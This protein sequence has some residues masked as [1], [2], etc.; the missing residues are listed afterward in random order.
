MG[1][2]QIGPLTLRLE[3]NRTSIP[4]G[5]IAMEDGFWDPHSLVTDGGIDPVLRGLA[6]T[7]QEAN[8]PG[9][10]HA[11]RNM[12]FGEP[13]MGGMDMCAIDIQRGRDH[14]IPDYGAFRAHIGLETANNWSDVTSNS[15]LASRLESVYPNVSSADPL[16][17][18]YAEDHD[19]IQDNITIHS[20][21]GPTMHY[22]I[23]DQFHRLRVSDPLFYEWDPD[24]ANVIDEIRNTTL[25]DVIPVSY[26]HLTLPT[27]CSV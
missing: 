25:T 5:S 10:I 1:H 17:G 16:M 22:I 6:F 24:L 3:E 2:S 19:W 15:E 23:N 11:L 12:L 9:Y 21:V 4:Q 7:T 27:I 20:T 14:G 13:G 8:D 26:T 18:M